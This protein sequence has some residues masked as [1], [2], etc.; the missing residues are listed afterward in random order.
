MSVDTRTNYC[1]IEGCDE[2]YVCDSPAIL[3]PDYADKFCLPGEGKPC[4]GL[5]CAD[6]FLCEANECVACDKSCFTCFI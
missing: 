3:G 5:G 4:D 6:G 2:G 1:P